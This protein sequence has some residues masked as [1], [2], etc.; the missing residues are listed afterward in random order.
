MTHPTD[1]LLNDFAI[2]SF[3]DVA[4]ED[5]I[6]ARLAFRARL[7]PQFLWGSLQA[8]E[9]YLKCILVLNRI[10]A[11][12]GHD[13]G[14]ILAEL[15]KN[16]LFELRLSAQTKKFVEF[17]DTYGRHRYFESSWYV[18]G[19]EIVDL[20]R[21]VWE[22]RRYARIMRYE[23]H[24]KDGAKVNALP[25]ELTHNTEAESRH[26]QDFHIMGGRLES[27]LEKKDHP[28]REPLVWQNGFFGSS[29]RKS[30]CLQSGIQA[31]N[32]PL[33]LHPELLD[34]VL[35]YVW[36]PKDVREAYRNHRN[37]S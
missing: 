28:A 25:I 13:L 26:P 9:K 3:R 33:T 29:H 17:L 24:G 27:I 30:V 11:S 18:M 6:A 4:D 37:A 15:E 36:L 23:F 10:P 34:E 7:I 16:K 19:G 31:A 8:L 5:Y 14:E 1:A 12:R 22:V 35:K 32:S 21:A 2:R 20:D